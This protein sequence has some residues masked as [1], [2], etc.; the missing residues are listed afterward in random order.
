MLT[1]FLPMALLL[2]EWIGNYWK[3][4]KN[5]FLAVCTKKKSQKRLFAGQSRWI[6]IAV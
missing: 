5:E 2:N 4:W 3:Q 6:L 1:E